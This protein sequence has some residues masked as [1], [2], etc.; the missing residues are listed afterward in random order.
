ME[1]LVIQSAPL[2]PINLFFPPV[3]PVDPS[4][5]PRQE[6]PKRPKDKEPSTLALLLAEYNRRSANPFFG[7]SKFNGEVGLCGR[8]W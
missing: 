1:P 2:L 6:I 4:Q 5:F 3:S 7:F 8:T